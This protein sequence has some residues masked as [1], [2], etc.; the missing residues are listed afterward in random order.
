[1]NTTEV[2]E[3]WRLRSQSEIEKGDS[4]GC[5]D[6]YAL[7]LELAGEHRYKFSFYQCP[8]MHASKIRD[9][10]KVNSLHKKLSELFSKK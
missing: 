6:G 3:L 5:T 2:D 9:F 4:L 8:D 10:Q 1:M 7:L